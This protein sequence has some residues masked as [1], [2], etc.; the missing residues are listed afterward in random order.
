MQA[1]LDGVERSNF[2]MS[3]WQQCKKR[4]EFLDFKSCQF[5]ED[6]SDGQRD[7]HVSEERQ[8]VAFTSMR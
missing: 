5:V 6:N 4:K 2:W 3:V 7:L 1:V 8:N